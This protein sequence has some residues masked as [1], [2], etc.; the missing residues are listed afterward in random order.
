MVNTTK[1]RRTTT[2]TPV[3]EALAQDDVEESYDDNDADA[4]D[5][6]EEEPRTVGTA[7]VASTKM[8]LHYQPL[9]VSVTD[10]EC[11]TGMLQRSLVQRSRMGGLFLNM[12]P[13]WCWTKI[14]FA[15][16]GLIKARR[17]LSSKCAI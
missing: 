17:K 8:R 5:D 14:K 6:S 2:S 10:M 12:T 11:R 4:V 9:H 3:S 7:L 15:K 1:Y 16:K 13:L